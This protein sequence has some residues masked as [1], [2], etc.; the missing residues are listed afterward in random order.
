MNWELTN[1]K[2]WEP[3]VAKGRNQEPS[4]KL[5][6]IDEEDT[7]L[8]DD[9][10]PDLPHKVFLIGRFFIALTASLVFYDGILNTNLATSVVVR[11]HTNFKT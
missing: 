4:N 9:I 7:G 5:N 6:D 3:L 1:Q 2:F 11:T 10:E 8:H